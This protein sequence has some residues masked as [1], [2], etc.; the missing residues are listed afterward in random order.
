[1]SFSFC[2]TMLI[3]AMFL[4]TGQPLH[5]KVSS[6]TD[7]DNY[8][9]GGRAENAPSRPLPDSRCEAFA[10][11]LST[12]PAGQDCEEAHPLPGV[13]CYHHCRCAYGTAVNCTCNSSRYFPADALPRGT[14]ATGDICRIKSTG[15]IYHA[16]R[17]KKGFKPDAGATTCSC[18]YGP[19]KDCLCDSR[20]YPL[21]AYGSFNHEL[22]RYEKCPAGEY[23]RIAGC[24]KQG[25]HLVGESCLLQCAPGYSAV[26]NACDDGFELTE[27]EDVPECKMCRR[28][29]CPASYTFFNNCPDG[30]VSVSHPER[31]DCFKCE[32]VACTG[33]YRTYNVCRF[34]QTQKRQETNPRC[35]YC[36]GEPCESGYTLNVNCASGQTMQTQ[37]S[38]PACQKCS[39]VSCASGYELIS[40]CAEGQT[41]H[42]QND[43]SQCGKCVGSP[44]QNGYTTRVSSCGAGLELEVQKTN[45]KCKRCVPTP[46]HSGF[47]TS[48]TRFDCRDGQTF[49]RQP[50]TS[51]GQCSGIP[52]AAGYSTTTGACASGRV[53][54]IQPGN[55]ACRKCAD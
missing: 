7:L 8:V 55:S 14:E 39:G 53:L 42:R 38:N 29:E 15:E 1:M 16:V 2:R 32:G 50:G 10:G 45:G 36:E 24:K 35:V 11:Y 19:D 52:C 20:E 6:I 28:I 34:G 51:C 22:Y 23:Y 33:K 13:T 41:L 9:G 12:V 44:C 3:A 54:L 26:L 27:Q 18:S 43:N 46:C 5:A 4:L 49:E 48:I 25:Y 30:T 37:P 17:C 21:P 40:A 31:P 47:S